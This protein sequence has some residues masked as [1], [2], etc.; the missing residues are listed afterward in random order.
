VSLSWIAAFSG[1]RPPVGVRF[2]EA[3]HDVGE[4][5]GDQ[6]ILLHQPQAPALLRRVVGIKDARQR[7]RAQRLG[8][9]GDEVAR[10]ETLKIERMQ[11]RRAP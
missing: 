3:A 5:A 10:A 8:H 11:R 4:R 2:A 9:R 6:E 1:Q 7:F